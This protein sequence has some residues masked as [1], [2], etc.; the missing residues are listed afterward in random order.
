MVLHYTPHATEARGKA[1][2]ASSWDHANILLLFQQH[3]WDLTFPRISTAQ[4]ND[5][6]VYSLY[7]PNIDQGNVQMDQEEG[8]FCYINI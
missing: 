4:T 1:W 8:I 5:T 6:K 7:L 2:I 3:R